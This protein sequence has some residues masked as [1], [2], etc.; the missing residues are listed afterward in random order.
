MKS[1]LYVLGTMATIGIE[2]IIFTLFW[3]LTKIDAV[4]M[5]VIC[6]AITWFIS[7]LLFSKIDEA[8]KGVESKKTND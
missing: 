1:F 4:E 6:C 3:A 5:V 7:I 2:A 8:Q